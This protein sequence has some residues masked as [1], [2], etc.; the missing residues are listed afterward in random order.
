MTSPAVLIVEDDPV[1]RE[2]L[3]DTLRTGEHPVFAAGSGAE[4]LGIMNRE[5]IGLVVSDL[6]M[7]PMDG[8]ELLGQIRK[9]H[10]ALPAVLMTAHGTIENAVDSMRNGASDYLVKP[11][12]ADDLQRV[13]DRYL[14]V[15]PASGQ[16][17]AADQKTMELLRVA[18][19]VAATNATVT[20][21]GESGCG[22]EIFAR[23]IHRNST[24]SANPFVAI[25]CAAIPEQMLEAVLFGYE[26]GAFTGATAAMP[27]KFEQA[28][29][30]TLLLDEI[31]EMDL[32]LQAKI[33][34]VIQEKE[35]E[36]LGSKNLIELDLRILATTNR[37][38][39]QHVADGL[40]REDLYYR[41]NV[42]PLHIPP[43]RQRRGDILPLALLAIRKHASGGRPLPVLSEC[44]QQRLLQHDWPG[45][46]REL[47]NVV[48]RSLILLQGNTITAADLVFED[49]VGNPLKNPLSVVQSAAGALQDDLKQREWQIIVDALRE[50]GGNRGDVSEKLGISP[51]TLRY[52]LARMREDGVAIPGEPGDETRNTSSQQ[53][54][55]G[56]VR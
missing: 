39:R 42:F 35:V 22:K 10:P 52:K 29:G 1:L 54:A 2:A 37:D 7:E 15:V 56:T 33:L 9:D 40:F 47:E 27:G 45:N 30:G 49:P 44:V 4:A 41:L 12:A 20:I 36:R 21:T 8:H 13:V 51:R 34:R 14:S 19:R 6:Q 31:S 28:Q 17:I 43:L 16:P 26:K 46:V 50:A 3:L 18:G 48:Q 24:R 53:S 25:N 11:F 5:S 55:R 23:Y 32:G 38:L